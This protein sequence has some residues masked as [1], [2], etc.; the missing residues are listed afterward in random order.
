MKVNPISQSSKK[1]FFCQGKNIFLTYLLI[2]VPKLRLGTQ[3][4]ETPFRSYL[5]TSHYQAPVRSMHP[6]LSGL[7]NE[8]LTIKSKNI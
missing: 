1:E 6:D 3:G 2:D 8:R 4:I 5:F 7:G